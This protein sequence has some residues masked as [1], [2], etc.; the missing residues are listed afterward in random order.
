M[1]SYGPKTTD[2]FKHKSKTTA[3]VADKIGSPQEYVVNE[4][5]ITLA[6]CKELSCIIKI[7][8]LGVAM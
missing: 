2:H 5:P 1:L 4:H 6:K 8:S 3:V 7:L